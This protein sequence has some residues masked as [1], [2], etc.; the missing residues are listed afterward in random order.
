MAKEVKLTETFPTEEAEVLPTV[1]I[2][3]PV[4]IEDAEWCFQFF[5]NDPIVFGWQ[6]EGQPVSP[7]VMQINPTEGEKLTFQQNGMTFTIFPRPITEE[8]KLARAAVGAPES[9]V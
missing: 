5:N 7:L 2:P 6:Q 8:T 3:E 9:A 4:K 1:Q